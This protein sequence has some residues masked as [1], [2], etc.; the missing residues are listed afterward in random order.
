[1]ISFHGMFIEMDGRLDPP[2]FVMV[3]VLADG[4]GSSDE[5]PALVVRTTGAGLGVMFAD[6]DRALLERIAGD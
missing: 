4:S 1:D 3:R 2:T 6:Y 5:I